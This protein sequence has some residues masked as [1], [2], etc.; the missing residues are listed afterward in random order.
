MNDLAGLSPHSPPH[1]AALSAL[2]GP[3]P[4]QDDPCRVVLAHQW[5]GQKHRVD[6]WQVDLGA[7]VWVSWLVYRA[8]P[9]DTQAAITL[10][11]PDGC[12]PH[13]V[14]GAA[15]DAVLAQGV[16]LAW[17]DR[18]GLAWDGPEAIRGGPVHRHWPHEPWSAIAVWAWGLCHSV[19]ALERVL[20]S[21]KL[22]VVG[23]SRGGKAALVAAVCDPRIQAV[24]AHNTGTGGV[25]RL[26]P[27]QPGA[28]SLAALAERFAHWLSPSVQDPHHQ[29]HIVQADLPAQYLPALAPRGLCI[30]QAE[31]DLWANPTGSRAMYD[32]LKP[33]WHAAPQR[34]CW[35]SRRGGHPM[36]ALDWQRAAEF[37]KPFV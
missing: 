30:L 34:L 15:M 7:P 2:F 33:A 29:A 1:L 22:A 14:N 10:L 17:F 20:T 32:H 5:Q 16:A 19:T 36:T 26:C 23:H 27:E 37:L 31:D 13:V 8:E 6:V 12:W 35:H 28:E 25:S 21:P 18:V 24:I 11:S 3:L 4:P 9:L